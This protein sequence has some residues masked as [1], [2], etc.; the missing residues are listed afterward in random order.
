MKKILFS[1][2][3]GAG[4]MLGA[5]GSSDSEKTVAVDPATDKGIGVYA[6]KE[7]DGLTEIDDVMA[8]KGKA[9]YEAKCIAC[10]NPTLKLAPD[11]A[12]ITKRQT[13]NWIMNMIIN[14]VQMTK[15]N[16]TAANLLKE[17]KNIQM[18]FQD[19]SEPDAR[20]ILEYFRKTDLLQ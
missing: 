1:A 18:T 9:I 8:Q 20:A 14:P 19:V 13:P 16:A 15:E 12:G 17:F 6:T 10:H 4:L 5:C 11:V 3:I 7:V 2:L